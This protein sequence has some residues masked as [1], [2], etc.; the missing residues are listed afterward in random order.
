MKDALVM[1]MVEF[2]RASIT[3]VVTEFA[4]MDIPSLSMAVATS[5]T[6]YM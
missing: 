6:N 3:T 2:I 5:I 1:G 4:T